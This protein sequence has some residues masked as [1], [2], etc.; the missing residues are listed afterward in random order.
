MVAPINWIGLLRNGCFISKNRGYIATRYGLY[1]KGVTLK[2][3]YADMKSITRS[4]Q[5]ESTRSAFRIYKE[6]CKLLNK[7]EHRTIRLIGVGIHNLSSIEKSKQLFFDDLL[8]DGREPQEDS[9]SLLKE[10]GDRYGLNFIANLDKIFSG[11]TLYKTIEYMR[12][13]K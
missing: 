1:G 7:V 13:Q 8:S 6:S 9:N 12:K 5:I 3:T 2:I 10:L 11:E 4:K